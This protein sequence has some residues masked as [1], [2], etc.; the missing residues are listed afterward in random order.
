MYILEQTVSCYFTSM[1]DATD[2]KIEAN[3][4]LTTLDIPSTTIV[5]C[6]IA[7]HHTGGPHIAQL[8]QD[9]SQT[10]NRA[11]PLC[12]DYIKLIQLHRN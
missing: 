12:V 8:P 9:A 6:L 3:Q 7:N 10:V 4:P 5:K 2:H 11:L 1:S